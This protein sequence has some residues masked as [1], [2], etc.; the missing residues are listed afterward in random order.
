MRSTWRQ[1]FAQPSASGFQGA[2]RLLAPLEEAL[3][4]LGADAS[5]AQAKAWQP[6]LV[7]ALEALELPAWLI[8]E[9][10]SDHNDLLYRRA[11]D[12]ALAEMRSA[13]W[14][15]PPVSFCV[16]VMGSGGRHESLLYPD[17]D[18][19]LILADYPIERHLEIDTWFLTLAEAYTRRLDE[20]GIP[21][22]RGQVMG[23][24]PLWR[25]PIGQWRQQL[26][27]W[28]ARRRVKL[29]QQ[30]N[31]LFDFAPL[32]GDLALAEQLRQAVFEPLPKAGLFLHEMRALLD[33]VPVA[34]DRFGR[35]QGEAREAPHPRAINLK[36]QAL[37]PLTAALRILALEHRCPRV[38]TRERLDWLA[39]AG[40]L[41]ASQARALKG[42]FARL[43]G[44]LL[45]VQM[46]RWQRGA[47]PDNWL[48]IRGLSEA[49]R[50]LLRQDL[51]QIQL[52]QQRARRH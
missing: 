36:R 10:L 51:R 3:A 27:L 50:E 49:E 29:V 9:L 37:L 6:R 5:L 33:E 22:C 16:L 7:Q 11:I 2:A 21:L 23:S 14:G 40:V 52:L 28:M 32:Y 4:A 47:R 26:Q 39:S 48:D 15:A 19:A 43:M 38:S 45:A 44:Q 8:C 35:L 20:A 1:L 42:V 12:Q 30:C 41:E 31:I 25:K 17:Q 34:L 18:N 46:E 13:G 24:R